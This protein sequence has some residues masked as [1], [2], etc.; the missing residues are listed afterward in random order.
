MC[1]LEH[2]LGKLTGCITCPVL[3]ELQHA[4]RRVPNNFVRHYVLYCITADMTH[5]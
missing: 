1:H 5:V 2:R 4:L 3:G